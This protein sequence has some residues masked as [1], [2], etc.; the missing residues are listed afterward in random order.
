M[1]SNSPFL[2]TVKSLFVL[3]LLLGFGNPRMAYGALS[4]AYTIDSSQVASATNYRDFLSA[5]S[6]M[7]L[8]T[9]SDG[10]TPNGAGVS[11]AVVFNVAAGVY[12]GQLE[13][14][15]ITGVS[16]TNTITFDGG[17]GNASTRVVTFNGATSLATAYTIRI[18][19]IQYVSIRNLTVL[20][21]S[22]SFGWPIHIMNVAS[23]TSVKQCIIGF[24]T[25]A[26]THINT[27]FCAVVV[28]NSTAS[29]TNAGAAVTNVEIDSNTIYGG[30]GNYL[31][32]SGTASNINFRKNQVDSTN[33]YGLYIQGINKFSVN[34]NTL[35]LNEFGNINGAGLFIN[36]SAAGTGFRH[37][38][39]GNKII[40]ASYY[41]V[42]LTNSGGQASTRSLLVNNSLG[43]GFRN[44]NAY[45]IYFGSSTYNW[46]VYHN[47][48][49]LDA[50]TTNTQNAALYV[51]NCCTQGSTLLNVRNNV[52][53]VTGV[54]STAYSV[55]FTNGY[56]YA[57]IDT[58]SFDY[59][60]YFKTGISQQEPLLY[61]GG[62]LLSASN[63]VGN[64]NYN[65]RSLF[66]NPTFTSNKNLAPFNPC[67]N[68]IGIAAVTTDV[69]GAT[70]NNLTPDIGAYELNGVS[71]DIG[72]ERFTAPVLPFNAGNQD[73]TVVIRNY[74]SNTVTSANV[75]YVVNGGTPVTG[76]YSGSI[77]PCGSATYTFSGASQ[78]NF[79][80][81][82][83]YSIKAYTDMPNTSLDASAINDT[84]YLPIIFTGLSG[85]Y[86][87]DQSLPASATN[88]VS[89]TDAVTALNN[90]G[91]SGAV[92]FTVMGST[93]YNEQV[94]LNFV[95]GTSATNTI[96]FDGGLGN[97]ANRILTFAATVPG[98]N[99]TFRINNTPWVVVRN[100]TIRGTGSSVA[101]PVHVSGNAS[102]N[103]TIANCIVN[104]IGG[105]G[106]T[107]A[108]DN[109][110]G[111]VLNGG[112]GSI[113]T[114]A[115]F[116]NLFV[117]SNTI[118][119]G[120]NGIYLYSQNG[121]NINVRGNTIT[122]A[123]MYGIYA[124]YMRAFRINANIVNMRV[125]GSA[126]SM[127][128]YANFPISNG[129]FGKEI[130]G[131]TVNNA[132][133][134]GINCFY[135]QGGSGVLR[136]KVM[137]NA[138]GGTFRSTDPAGIYFNNYCQNIDVFFNSV[139]INNPSTALQSGAFKMQSYCTGISAKNN[140]FAVTNVNSTAYALWSDNTSSFTALDY[141]NYFKANPI[142]LLNING[143]I[144]NTTS[145]IG[146]AGYNA[147]AVSV[148]P[149]YVSATDLRSNL[150]C[151]HGEVIA[152]VTTDISGN[153][154]NTPPDIGAYENTT[155]VANDLA[156]LAIV[157][158]QI[159]MQAGTQNVK[160]L[161][162]NNG[163]STISSANVSY[164][165][166]SGTTQSILWTG[167]LNA[168]D[169]ATVEF[170]ATSGAGASDQRY[171]FLPGV[172]YEI[173]AY[174]ASPNSSTDLN[175]LNDTI[176]MGPVCASLSGTYTIDSSLAASATNFVSFTSAVQSMACAGIA[177]PVLFNVAA[178]TYPGQL[179]F[180][181]ILGL[182]ATNTITFD[183]GAGNDSTRIVTFSATA[184]NARHTVLFNNTRYITMRNLTIQGTGTTYAWP[185]HIWGNSSYINI[186]NTIIDIAGTGYNG[187]S[188]NYIS[189]V[190]SGSQTSP[191]STATFNNISL[192]NN[193]L[194][195]G[196]ANLYMS[197]NGTNT[198]LVFNGNLLTNS[199]NYGTYVSN[200]I[201]PKFIGNT[202]YVR[203]NST[204]SW[205]MYFVN[206]VT[207]AAGITEVSKNKIFDAG[208]YGIQVTSSNAT[209][210]RSVM[211]NNSI[212][213]L[214]RNTSPNGIHFT[215]SNNWNVW[216]NSVLIANTATSSTTSAAAYLG[217][218]TGFDFRNNNLA[219]TDSNSGVN[220]LPL[221]SLSGVT[222]TP[223]LNYNN[224]YRA[225]SPTTLISVNGTNY[226][227]ANYTTVGGLNSVSNS[228]GFVSGAELIPTLS[229]NNG[230]QIAG[231][232]NDVNDS[233]RNNPPDMG[234]YEI[235]S[236]Y[237]TDLGIA[238]MI[239]PDNDLTVGQNTVNVLV[240]NFGATT[241]TGFNIR[242]SV[243][244]SNMQDSAITGVSIAPNDTMR[245]V[246]SGNKS[247]L[248]N[249]GVTST[250]KAYIHL[251]NGSVDD[252]L[253]N[254]TVTV[255]PVLGKLKGIYTINPTG[256]GVNNFVSF[257]S[258]ADALNT[259]GVSGAVT[260]VVAAATYNEQVTINAITGAS[261]TNTIVFD[262]INA[263]TRIIDTAA[264][265]TTNYWT[266]KL[267]SATYVTFKNLTINASGATYGAAV[268]IAGTSNYSK[269]LNCNLNITTGATSTSN[270][271]IPLL[272][273]NATA[274]TSATNGSK[275][276]YLQID[277][278]TINGGYYGVLLYGNTSSPYSTQNVFTNNTIN[279]SYY[280]GFY[281]YY[282]EAITFNGNNV[283]VRNIGGTTNSMGIYLSS[284]YNNLTG[285]MHNVNNNRVVD[286]GRYGIYF[287]NGGGTAT[288][289][290]VNNM[291]GGGF[292]N[293]SPNGMYVVGM[294][295]I[296]LLHNS[297]YVDVLTTG[298]QSG[299]LYLA[300]NTNVAVRNNILANLGAGLPL[301][302]ANVQ[303]GSFDLDGNNY[304]R[305]GTS[306]GSDLIYVN[307]TTY[308]TNN[309]IGAGG[310]N[311][312]SVNINPG[313]VS[314]T[315]LHITSACAGKVSRLG[316][317]LTD[318]DGNP[319]G[320]LTNIGA[321]EGVASANDA[322]V[323]KIQPFS[324]GLQDVRVVIQN[325]GSNVLTGANVSYSVNGN[326]PRVLAWSGTL[327]PCDTVTVV[328]SGVNQFNF[329]SGVTYTL[330]AFTSSPNLSADSKNSNDTTILGPTCVFLSGNYTINASGSGARNFT[331]FGQAVSALTC[332]GVTGAVNID[333]APGTY[334]EQ[335]VF[336]NIPGVSATNTV[337][338][339]GDSA[340]TRI[341]EFNP[342]VNTSAFT[343]KFE[344]ASFVTLRNLT[345]RSGGTS[346]FAGAVHI[347]NNCNNIKLV[348]NNIQ[349]V[350][351]GTTSA[352]QSYL[353]VLV[354]GSTNINSPSTQLANTSNIEIDSNNILSGYAAVYVYGNSSSYTNNIL[355][356]GNVMDSSYQY[357][358]YIYFTDRTVL[359]RNI[360]NMRVVGTT[361]SYGL[362][363]SNVNASG[364]NFISVVG[365]QIY[366][367]GQSGIYGY[368]A[369][370]NNS[371]SR[372]KM[373]NNVIGGNFRSTQSNPLY[374]QYSYYWDVWHNTV[375]S[376][377]ATTAEQYSTAYFTN[378]TQLDVRNNHFINTSSGGSG[379]PFF[380]AATNQFTTLDFNNYYNQSGA[381]LASIAGITYNPSTITN[382]GGFNANP[383][384]SNPGFVSAFNLS[385]SNACINGVTIAGVT[386][387]INNVTRNLPPDVGAYE[388]TG[389]INNDIGVA[390]LLSPSVPFA[391]GSYPIQV[392][393]NNYGANTIT[394]ATIKYS[395]NNAAPVSYAYSGTL[396]PCDTVSLIISAS[397]V[398]FALGTAYS[399]KVWTELPNGQVDGNRLNDTLNA[400]A[401]AALVAGNYTINPSGSGSTNFTSFSAAAD[402]LNCGGITGPVRFVVSAGTYNEQFA[403]NNVVGASA[404][405]TITFDGVDKNTRIIQ[406]N[407]TNNMAAHTVRVANTPYV[408]IRN[409]SIVSQGASFGNPMHI[410][411]GSDGANIVNN[412]ITFSGTA[413]TST[414]GSYIA[415]LVNNE[416]N[417]YNPALTGTKANNI[418]ID[419]NN[420]SYGYYGVYVTGLTQNPYSQGL[421]MRKNTIDSSYYY[422]AYL[423]YISGVTV[424]GNTVNMRSGNTNAQG[425]S[426]NQLYN[427]TNALHNIV[428]NKIKGAG[429]YG[430][431]FYFASNSNTA[432]GNIINNSISGGFTSTSSAGIYM[433]YSTYWNIWHN[434]VWLDVATT[435][436]SQS[437]AL[438]AI[439]SST[440][441]DIRNNHFVYSANSGSGLSMYLTST[442]TALNNNNYFNASSTTLLYVNANYTSSNFINGGGYNANSF[443]VNPNFTSTA[444][445]NAGGC[446]KGTTLSAVTTDINGKTRNTIPDIGAYESSALDVSIVNITAPTEPV[447]AGLQNVS[448]AVKNLGGSTI[449]SLTVTYNINNSGNVSQTFT[450]LTILPCSTSTVTFTGANQFNFPSGRSIVKVF[451]SNPN[452][453]I[454]ND[455]TND[456]LSRSLCGPLNG[457]YT[458]NANLSSASNFTSFNDAVSS[459]LC[460]G[461]TGPVTFNVAP[462]TYNEQ[463][464]IPV[465]SGASSFNT[466]TFRGNPSA[467]NSTILTFASNNTNARH[468][469]KLDSANYV[470]FEYLTIRTEGVSFGWGV[471]IASTA[472]FNTIKGCVV[473]IAGTTAPNSTSTN[474]A[475]IV[476]NGSNTNVTTSGLISDL[477]IDSN[478]INNGYYGVAV[479]GNTTNTDSSIV[480][481]RNNINNA[482]YYGAY[483]YSVEGMRVNSNR[484]ALRNNNTN[485][486]GIFVTTA[487]AY[488]ANAAFEINANRIT[489]VGTYGVYLN[490]VNGIGGSAQAKL[491][492]NMIGGGFTGSNAT[493]LYM[494]SSSNWDVYHNSINLDIATNSINYACVYMSGTIS[495]TRMK[496]NH[497]AYTGLGG[498]GLTMYVSNNNMFATG[499]LNYNNYY[500]AGITNNDNL[501]YV[502]GFYTPANYIN[503]GGYNQNSFNRLPGFR[504]NLNLATIDGCFNGDSLGVLADIDGDV[505]GSFGDI[506]A[507]EVTD[508]NND[509]GVLTLLQP[510]I[511]L[512]AGL[513]DISVIVKNFGTNTVYKGTVNYSINGGTPVS[514]VFNDTI[515]PCDTAIV[516]FTGASQF[517]FVAGA[518]YNI[519]AYTTLPND[520]SDVNNVNDTLSTPSLCISLAGNYTI[521][522]TGSGTN[523]F[524]TFQG[525]LDALAC[526]G[527]SGP[528]VFSVAA[529]TYTEQLVVPAIAGASSVN[530]ITFD[531]GA[532]NASTRILTFG[533]TTTNA[534]QTVRFSGAQYVAFNNLTIRNTGTT[535]AWPVHIHS[536][537]KNIGLTNN[538]IEIT[539]V[540]A[541]TSSQ[542][543]INVVVSASLNS[544]S[545]SIR[546]DSITIDSNTINGGYASVYS[547]NQQS[548]F[549][550]FNGNTFNNPLVYGLYMYN[551]YELKFRNNLVNMSPTGD[552]TSV[553]L[554]LFVLGTVNNSVNEIT[555]NRITNAGQYGI[556]LY[557][558][559]GNFGNPSL[560]VNNFI[561]GGFRNTTQHSGI[562]S[563]YS[564]SWN[565]WFNTVKLDTISN[566]QFGAMHAQNSSNLDVRNNIFAVTNP[567]S[568]AIPYYGAT[569]GNASQ[570]NY[571]NYY[572]A[573]NPSTLIFNGVALAPNAYVG[574]N[575]FN[576]NSFSRDPLFVG[577]N[578][579]HVGNGCNNGITIAAVTT[580]IDGQTRT[581]PPDVGADEVTT[582]FTNNIGVTQILTPSTPLATGTSDVVVVV[583]NL[584]NNLVTN[585]NINYSVNGGTPVTI[586]YTDT[587][588]PCDTAIITFTG[589]QAYNFVQGTS[590]SIKAYTSMPNGVND[591]NLIDD[592][593]TLGP[594]CPAMSGN[595]TID[596]NGT[597]TTNFT[598][599]T[600][601]IN[602]L[603]CAGISDDVVF[604]IANGTYNEQIAINNVA[605][606]NDTNTV[607]FIGQSRT[608]VVLTFAANNI[609][610]AH[611]VKVNSASNII[612][613]NLTM[614]STGATMGV[615]LH[616]F[617]S[618]NNVKV[619]NTNIVVG[620]AGANS[621]S[622]NFIAVLVNANAN[623]SSPT[624]GTGAFVNNLEIDSNNIAN[625]Y[626]GILAYG[627]SNNPY[628]N[629]VNF[630]ANTI[631]SSYYYGIYAYYLSGTKINNN[632][633]NMRVV[634]TTG[635]IGIYLYQCYNNTGFKH[636]VNNNRI[637]DAGSN[638]FYAYFSSGN[639]T[640]PNEFYNN[641]IGGNFR[642]SSAAPAYFQYANYWNVY[643][644]SINLALAT[645]NAQY[646][647]LTAT[648]STNLRI[649]NNILAYNATSGTGLPLY[650]AGAQTV[651][652]YNNYVNAANTNMLFVNGTTYTSAN[653]IGGG[654]Y[655]ANGF[656]SASGFTS[657]R[658][659]N[660]TAATVKGDATLGITTDIDGQLRQSP[661]DVGADEYFG[662]MDIGIVAIDSPTT[663]VFCG[664]NRNVIVKLRNFGNQTVSN[665]TITVTI[666]GVPSGTYNW[667]GSLAPGATS[668]QINAGS[669]AFTSGVYN[670][671]VHSSL[672]NFVNDT[673]FANDTSRQVVTT[674]LSVTPTITLAASQTT[675]C[676]GQE[677]TLIA[678]YT[679]GGATPTIQWRNNGITLPFN[680][681]TLRTTTLANNDSIVVILSSSATC[682][683]PINVISNAV[684]MNVGT[685]V[686]AMVSM[687]ASATTVCAGQNVNFTATPTNG[688]SSPTYTW[689]K[690]GIQVGGDSATYAAVNPVNGDSI[691]V[692]LTSSLGCASPAMD[693]AT[694]IKLTV[695]PLLLPTASINASATTFCAGTQVTL[696]ATTTNTGT[697]PFYQWKRNGVNVGTNNDTLVLSNLANNDSLELVL[698]SNATCATPQVVTSN[699]IQVTVNP[700]VTP[701]VSISSNTN[702]VCVGTQVNFNATPV[703]A[704]VGATYSWRVNGTQVGTASTYSSSALTHLDTV[705]LVVITDTICAVPSVVSSNNI[706][707]QINNFVNPAVTF[708]ASADTVCAGTAVT[709]VAT[710]TNGGTTPSYQWKLN[711]N[712]VGTDSSRYSAVLNNNDS[713]T[714]V[715]TSNATCL[716]QSTATTSYK[717][718]VVNPLAPTSIFIHSAGTSV[719]AGS[720]ILFDVSSMNGG[721]NPIYQWKRNGVNVG[722]NADTFR[723]QNPVNGDSIHVVLTSNA[724][725][726]SPAV[727]ESAKIGITVTPIVTSAVSIVASK[728]TACQGDSVTFTAT[729][730][731]GGLTPGYKWFKNGI[732]VANNV[733]SYTSNQLTS[734]DSVWVELNSSLA[735]V[736]STTVLSNK[737]KVTVNPLATPTVSVQA[738][739]TT[740]CAGSPITFTAT[741]T[742]TG[743][744]PTYQWKRN[745]NNVGTNNRIYVATAL[746]NNDSV[747]VVV[748]S[749]ATCTTTPS[750]TSAKVGIQITTPVTPNVSVSVSSNNICAGTT[751]TY[752]ATSINGGA[753]PVYAWYKNGTPVGTNSTTYVTNSLVD[754]D[755]VICIMTATPGCLTQTA[756]TAYTAAM[757]V[758]TPPAKP[759]VVK[760]NNDS[761][762]TTFASSGYQW[763][764]NGSAISGATTRGL[765]VPSNGYYQVRVDSLGCSKLSDSLLMNNV[766]LKEATTISNV[767][768]Y[769]NP[770][771][772]FATVEATFTSKANTTI[773]V[774]DMFG[775]L[776]S[777]I[778]MGDITTLNNKV[779]LSSLADGVYF[780]QIKHG[781]DLVTQRVVK[782][783]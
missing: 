271:F 752:T 402:A 261:A 368:F 413:Q 188:N 555:G 150:T 314:N 317:V 463:V 478:Q 348:R 578:D 286:A 169:T 152:S 553:G 442:P 378:C 4:G 191:T 316:S 705:S 250:F 474:F 66:A 614:Q 459:M 11:G 78:Y 533:A 249:A 745:G 193:K 100:L 643:H 721:T 334:N 774:V 189:V 692:V 256:S 324:S 576:L 428:G 730:T 587:I 115:T 355:I 73:I 151:N 539:G 778:E 311:L 624:S 637:Y 524:T 711:G 448:V 430:M 15:G 783:D 562:F 662:L 698:T 715:L 600:A 44:T 84:A 262:G 482:Y 489:S 577:A 710:P 392:R 37:E 36:S 419:S 719:C 581:S 123:N 758:K 85:N 322:G 467:V 713:V 7:R 276:D 431:Y 277:S 219:V 297:V 102:S 615:P 541:T 23:N 511:P 411:G 343:V 128:I 59:N 663:N 670:L 79:T 456:T 346:G 258:A 383:R 544:P 476:A 429:R 764:R 462:G 339:N 737:V 534:R 216:F 585:A 450:G 414:G 409:L 672:P 394:S 161:V 265:T 51:G 480:I 202:I 475:G 318:Y 17:I 22:P 366:N 707:M 289:Y 400:G 260:F 141:N 283:V 487:T 644:N 395:I 153:T 739:Q 618:A 154:R 433:Q 29:P 183:G 117:D 91:V 425:F 589:V 76:F 649:A 420:I 20:A 751:V 477:V 443:N 217:S 729:P 309:Y 137:N 99:H 506:G 742:D 767:S 439:N 543:F 769:P 68:G 108:N 393:I 251:P 657:N 180:G 434:S 313:F 398:S 744:T 360:L 226:T 609:N 235:A 240:K 53:A 492:N 282:N 182:S 676:S 564:S 584:G 563:E 6:D 287:T 267:N 32:G 554:Y 96:T 782:A 605:G 88:F 357:G 546:V 461:I 736:T 158:P 568:N 695:N 280:Y 38:V 591:N 247:A 118:T 655:N 295:N 397:N 602:A 702:N 423:Y 732:Q 762:S 149:S 484:I 647:T 365:N 25:L 303:N 738:N 452:A 335:L 296:S 65:K 16:A 81:N 279:S 41:G 768:V 697:A 47:S 621:G 550:N 518:N 285:S 94:S 97:A 718:T 542:N 162:K 49:N 427:N 379:L 155:T 529:G 35:N 167:T 464:R 67:Y 646:S 779:N 62:N 210:G 623:V 228:S 82:T 532:G 215:T 781:D 549:N 567:A 432:V 629:E 619:K 101:W 661:P 388:F 48:V 497:F 264:N 218:G 401:C 299:A 306:A 114:N 312:A 170:T 603:Q 71:N 536:G 230:I 344:G 361:S 205:G 328:F 712:N 175:V 69:N 517:N 131:N 586:N 281:A 651:I 386:T 741:A 204:T 772:G 373:V 213:G 438:T 471:H 678:S 724:V 42:Y 706:I 412:N 308:N 148:H 582:G 186:A 759:V 548:I 566:A 681:D 45:G 3:I 290:V 406:F 187:N 34:N 720:S 537:S 54:G 58:G 451:T 733:A 243:N 64:S 777:T 628:S 294:Q 200:V 174:S 385:A 479:Y 239:S 593:T 110:T 14:T 648:N 473:D 125:T 135:L 237:N 98:S 671:A 683:S 625:G 523:N 375:L 145:M 520:S 371:T 571:N 634:G 535:W 435:S 499:G 245:I 272:I 288:S 140:N 201:G 504:T 211:S 561:G 93:P 70:R 594:L 380:A 320:A 677:V 538:V 453:S 133:Q 302:T 354:S 652:N 241:I 574:A 685:T 223:A 374:M 457:T 674:N 599:I 120:N 540:G 422:G 134:Y 198:N 203:N 363:L 359:D 749:S 636:Q 446:F 337:T 722:I 590:Y 347:A 178:G 659:L 166:N 340:A 136:A 405:N 220:Y 469:V 613:R 329:L 89:F 142:R 481:T 254:D 740:A 773:T 160:V 689:Y 416:A 514:L 156:V 333:V 531:G 570:L 293:T 274:I 441:L 86:T 336:G 159:P 87:I 197:G 19:N 12:P 753:T 508:A 417:I 493:G 248:I 530:T 90:G 358:A 641:M 372:S 472:K 709:F 396:N 72:V 728:L 714:V 39:I 510:T 612:I 668:A 5:V 171:T 244:G 723:L 460:A 565:I 382:G 691:N 362:Y 381:N 501:L 703:N 105:N 516:T 80:A 569:T 666:N 404:I 731:N 325:F 116:S 319:R 33:Y 399:I 124:Y 415:V 500:K 138:V 466:I 301:Y 690:N 157:A 454:D 686:P 403:L 259:S 209:V 673:I 418:T 735:C 627:R 669:F 483:L 449:T 165:V 545:N 583:S 298:N 92:T 338:F 485:S 726:A 688:G 179:E 708:T 352:S 330:T 126:S 278:N 75:S 521:N 367:A 757:V 447:M 551:A 630:R 18:N 465:I 507:D 601:A 177:G 377:V 588:L 349:I 528:V 307:N 195:G 207:T 1:K 743:A 558:S 444:E 620:G 246:L 490:A 597:G 391:P 682:A 725:C 756:D 687:S 755:Q 184:N 610:N 55:Y 305:F 747:W 626:Y 658:N 266:V 761:L 494:N 616:V 607:S 214:F 315:N 598:T 323:V 748:T 172:T 760:V 43:G 642:T 635:S 52:F 654:S 106:V 10:G 269:I 579:L 503:G 684:K 327:N 486:Q 660:L 369:S 622:S 192:T 21:E 617:G 206:T 552:I 119:G 208:Q 257:R 631:D 522:P 390:T 176:S 680:G 592:T 147:N 572:K 270:F 95:P 436:A 488:S 173:T 656:N 775:R 60:L 606:S 181:D 194:V 645:S 526:S 667:S 410:M 639:S 770:T 222:F 304:Y 263:A 232:N 727:N 129:A 384:F 61:I 331:T 146:G 300:S 679:G 765:K 746:S 513:K 196:Y 640:N 122:D 50:I 515:Q 26:S 495:N 455:R 547:Y 408:T 407:P 291:I 238:S 229:T 653:Y 632:N 596:A 275:V 224:Y 284:C 310:Y 74:G 771:S 351:S 700:I 557:S 525:A 253:I 212:G 236:N 595:Y 376:N 696:A 132:G 111:I 502:T 273:S 512:T 573:G 364:T 353:P 332:G 13:I 104:F 46:D 56:T 638:G 252:N 9:R 190:M 754:G 560:V 675:I 527:V 199:N 109:F 693:T 233:I 780:I 734:N 292:R 341:L 750:A 664:G 458:I 370:T 121:E 57:V 8:G 491:L 107:G 496:N 139:N 611:T 650:S 127:G 326:I 234:A 164:R 468:T 227:P 31:Y 144:Y 389:S 112:S 519:R 699:K 509:L 704:G 717:T 766:G 83:S 27:N 763:F 580:D 40:N 440:N 716:N 168:C 470:S 608:G 426:F 345:I 255:G 221:R 130:I 604:T 505:R 113:S 665:A 24:S 28:N 242:H 321:D 77:P 776:I 575:G 2:V 225:G 633:L 143:I 556:Y 356:R 701:S 437:S 559:S 342:S 424:N 445:L 387:D 268:H 231:I 163:N 421:L 350:G 694:G 63:F 30:Y 498:T 185:V 103:I